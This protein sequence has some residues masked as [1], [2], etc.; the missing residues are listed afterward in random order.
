MKKLTTK[1]YKNIVNSLIK[2]KKPFSKVLTDEEDHSFQTFEVTYEINKD[3]FIKLTYITNFISND[4]F[5]DIYK[6]GTF[7][8]STSFIIEEI[9]DIC[10]DYEGSVVKCFTNTHLDKI[11][12]NDYI[13]NIKKLEDNY[14]IGQ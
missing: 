11:V 5:F 1:N 8:Y 10:I 9:I 12:F 4:P 7:L 2:G 3:S 14:L 13:L 6:N